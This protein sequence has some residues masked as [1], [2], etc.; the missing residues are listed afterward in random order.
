MGF[1]LLFIITVVQM[2]SC[3]RKAQLSGVDAEKNRMQPFG[4]LWIYAGKISLDASPLKKGTEAEENIWGLC[5]SNIF[6]DAEEETGQKSG[7]NA[8]FF[9]D[10]EKKEKKTCLT[11]RVSSSLKTAE[12]QEV[13]AEDLLFNYYIRC[14][15][16]GEEGHSFAAGIEGGEEYYYGTNH[17]KERKKKLGELLKKPGKELEKM[18]V[19]NLVLPELTLEY[20]WVE[21]MF[22]K[23]KYKEF[24]KGYQS[25]AEF[26]SHFYAYRT[27]YQPGKKTKEEI[28][29]EIAGQYGTNYHALEKVTGKSYQEKAEKYALSLLLKQKKTDM[30]KSIRGLRKMDAHTIR[31]ILSDTE[32]DLQK[33]LDFWLLPLRNYGVRGWEKETSVWKKGNAVHVL[34]QTKKSMIGSNSYFCRSMG[35]ETLT[36]CKNEYALNFRKEAGKIYIRRNHAYSVREIV[37]KML[38]EKIDIAVFPYSRESESLIKERKTGAIEKLALFFTEEET[39]TG[40]L[41]RTDYVNATTLPQGCK[42]IRRFF[43]EAGRIKVNE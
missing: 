32:P 30:V 1:L 43:C 9:Y 28:I 14:D 17:I 40:I 36:F 19:S 13:T 26:F 41:Y 21:N 2:S 5:F 23:E 27:S 15:P 10:I 20:E 8:A 34:E 33:Y 37:E 31:L 22:S 6:L 18:I 16:A 3:G 42:S 39:D 7:K 4:D 25:A 12:G 38:D 35:E 29:S 11:I 24:R